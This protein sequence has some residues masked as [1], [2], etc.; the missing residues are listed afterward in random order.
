MCESKLYMDLLYYTNPFPG[1]LNIVHDK[2]TTMQQQYKC[3]KCGKILKHMRCLRAHLRKQHADELER[4]TFG[5]SGCKKR[6]YSKDP[7][8]KHFRS[9]HLDKHKRHNCS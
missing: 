9:T 4:F 6:F 2:L 3:L 5:C 8:E 1:S 7:L